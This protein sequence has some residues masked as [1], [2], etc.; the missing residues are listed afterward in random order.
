M[1]T[2][3][4]CRAAAV[5]IAL[6]AAVDP[7]WTVARSTP[8]RVTVTKAEGASDADVAR[9][10]SVLAGTFTVESAPSPET[11]VRVIV[12][13]HVPAEAPGGRTFAVI[14]PPAEAAPEIRDVRVAAEVARD[15][16]SRVTARLAVPAP[17]SGRSLRVSLLADGVPVDAQTVD[18]PAGAS[19]AEA[20]L[21]FVPSREG[22]TRLRVSAQHGDGPEAWAETATEVTV[23]RLRVLAYD[24]R[25][26]WAATFLRRSLEEDPR[27][28]VVVRAVTSRGVTADAGAPPPDLERAEALSGFDAVIVSAPEVLGER[29]ADALEAYLR[30]REGVVVL[31]P[32]AGGGAVLS[33][34]AR[35]P[36]WIDER[37]PALERIESDAGA[38]TASEFLWPATLPAGA[39]AVTGCLAPGRCA[40]WRVPVGGGRVIVSSAL[41]GWRTRADATAGFAPFWRSLVGDEAARTPRPVEITLGTRVIE[42]GAW[43]PAEVRMLDRAS[44]PRAEW[45]SPD[46]AAAPVRLWPSGDGRYATEFRAPETPGRYRLTVVES[47]TSGVTHGEFLVVD[48]GTR[49]RPRRADDGW[50]GVYASASGGTAVTMAE[51][52]TLAGAIAAVVPREAVAAR[53]HPM[54]AW[55]WLLPFAGLLSIEWWARRRRGAR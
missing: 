10:R 35:V 4:V 42:A 15:A 52:E 1:T 7:A 19:S 36:A 46:G 55:W 28:E 2:E 21:M 34:L 32:E 54:R 14:P 8:A 40:V 26:S 9:V 18:V 39:E 44:V 41:D 53:E 27:V 33:R 25:P 5:G 49:Q 24:A 6:L 3:R 31:V 51:V 12:G 47:S 13:R 29:V 17:A 11:A 16:V 30:Q 23:R 48:P 20:D 22:V 45:Q 37:R 43:L 38:W 50:M